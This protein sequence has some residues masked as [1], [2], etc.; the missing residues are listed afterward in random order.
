M[1]RFPFYGS[2]VIAKS[3]SPFGARE[4]P[5]VRGSLHFTTSGR[6]LI[7]P[8]IRQQSITLS[9]VARSRRGQPLQPLPLIQRPFVSS[10]LARC[11]GRALLAR[12]SYR[13]L[14][15][16]RAAVAVRR[17]LPRLATSPLSAH[18][19]EAALVG[20]RWAPAS[21]SFL[22]LHQL[23]AAFTLRRFARHR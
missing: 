20:A 13:G 6:L 9:H 21:D 3:S 1:S 14:Y 10:I 16:R 11:A 7:G 4:E 19:G 23:C 18:H 12:P 8:L 15:E 5:T 2:V 17:L 22:R